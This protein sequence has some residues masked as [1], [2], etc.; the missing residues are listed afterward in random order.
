MLDKVKTGR[1]LIKILKVSCVI[2][3][4][5]ETMLMFPAN[6]PVLEG[7]TEIDDEEK[8]WPL[9]NVHDLEKI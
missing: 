1:G 6:H 3:F 5:V 8:F 9:L 7:R 2:Q 4:P